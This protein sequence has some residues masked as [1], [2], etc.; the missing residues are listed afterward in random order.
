MSSHP[1]ALL[2]TATHDHKRGEDVRTR[3]DALTEMP[4]LWNRA[5]KRWSRYN[6]R[7][8]T[9]VDA[10]PAPTANDEYLLYQTLVGTWPADWLERAPSEDELSGY[11][12]RIIEYVRKAAREA[13]FRTSWSNPNEA[14]ETAGVNFAERVLHPTRNATFHREFVELAREVAKVGAISSLSQTAL[15]LTSP[16]VP[17][18]YQGCELW[19]LSLVDPDNRR[20]VDFRARVAMLEDFEARCKR[21]GLLALAQELAERWHDGRMKA[22]LTWRL[23]HLRRN[24]AQTFLEGSYEPLATSGERAEQLVAFARDDIVV[25]VPRLVRRLLD[26]DALGLRVDFEDERITL[27][28]GAPLRYRDAVTGAIQEATPSNGIAALQ[29]RDLF[30]VLPVAVLIP[31]ASTPA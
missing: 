14:Y 21:G 8:K 6:E 4:G 19:D 23:L 3:L 31:E 15:K 11:T 10:S 27:R 26:R 9:V 13:K 17:D 7:K 22:L 16:G 24:R 12:Q 28:D 5:L 20:E 2:A 30:S 29:A 25:V 18:V 1:H